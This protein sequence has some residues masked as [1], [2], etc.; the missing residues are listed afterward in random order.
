MIQVGVG[1]WGASWASEVAASPH[2]ELVGLADPDRDPLERV[3]DKVGVEARRRFA[4]LTAALGEV[5]ADAVLVV[6]PPPAHGRL[7]LEA[8]EA[9]IH[10]LVEK[11]LSPSIG[12][13]RELVKRAE[14]ASRLLMA[15][16][17]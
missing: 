1:A 3:G 15:A 8:L 10:C 5:E 12:E 16:Q 2:W 9:G 4:S 13:A 7:A 14:E 11:P 17:N 6:A